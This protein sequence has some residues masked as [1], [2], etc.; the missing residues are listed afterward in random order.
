[1]YSIDELIK[2]RRQYYELSIG[3]DNAKEKVWIKKLRNI[4]ENDIHNAPL[5]CK[6][7]DTHIR[8]GEVHLDAFF[9]AQILFSHV[10]WAKRFSD[11]IYEKICEKFPYEMKKVLLIGFETYIEPVL[12]LVKEKNPDNVSYCIYEEPKY[13]QSRKPSKL[14][15]R[16]EENLEDEYSHIVYIC[17]ISSTLSTFGKM[18]KLVEKEKNKDSICLSIIQV[19]PNIMKD[20]EDDFKFA[21]NDRLTKKHNNR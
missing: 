9:E 20:T 4:L 14:R 5:G 12:N 11:W 1:M 18:Q 13:I 7:E 16:Y 17:G 2:L 6:I 3:A 10:H 8:I 21:I 15:L 19:L